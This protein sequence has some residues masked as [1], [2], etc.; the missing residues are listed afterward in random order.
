[1]VHM[2]VIHLAVLLVP[3]M[4]SC[5]AFFLMINIISSFVTR[6]RQA[7]YGAKCVFFEIYI[8]D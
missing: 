3:G 8:T 7:E 2:G 1:M 5:N 4:I 6:I